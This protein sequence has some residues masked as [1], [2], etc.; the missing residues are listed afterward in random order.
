MLGEVE[1][2]PSENRLQVGGRSVRVEPKTMDVLLALAGAGGETLGREALVAQ[3]WPRGFVSDDALNRCISQLRGALGDTPRSPSFIVTV[4]RV[5]YRLAQAVRPLAGE[6]EAA[7]AL[8]LPFQN[9]SEKA[10]DYIADGLTELLI[11]RLSVALDQPVISRTTAM[12]FRNTGRDLRSIGRQL[13]V[14]WVV[15]GSV[16]QLG[17][18]VQVVVQLID[19][20]SDT[21]VW[22]ETWTRGAGDLL[23]VLNEISRQVSATI[24]RRLAA[25]EARP[26][27]PSAGL[28][29]ALLRKYLH[30]IQL[31][32]RRTHEA[33]RRAGDCFEQVLAEQPGHAPSLGG[34]S[35]VNFL[36]AHYGAVPPGE[37]FSRA[38]AYARQA[39]DEDPGL[40]EAKIHLA[41]VEFFHAWNF[42]E[43]ERLLNEALAGNP[44]LEMAYLLRANVCAVNRRYEKAQAAIDR[45]LQIDPLNVGVLMNAGDHLI[46][47]R[48]YGEAVSMLEAAL[49][50][51][52][53]FRPGRLRLALA[54]ALDGRHEAA[55]DSLERAREPGGEDSSWFEYRAIL[56]GLAGDERGAKAAAGRLQDLAAGAPGPLSWALA[57]A[58]AAA[59]DDGKALD[60]LEQAYRE[61]SSSMPFLGVT[62]VF[63][64]LRGHAGMQALMARVGLSA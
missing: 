51:L 60:F 7:G 28:P 10:T 48:R 31:V 62:P 19:A 57:R 29:E 16:L 18:Q 47:Q 54:Q 37:G 53:G 41:A 55:A 6:P 1:V 61:R 50:L 58:W 40:A 64:R 15:E 23:A 45:A 30:G 4:P 22:A 38:R 32:S 63:D 46:L 35:M 14:R 25:P 2:S 27:Q 56:C 33:L 9:L 42:E 49:E 26:E 11:A 3:V 59:A 20:A 36:L 5:G 44:G 8:V 52:D 39:L 24:S 34:L 12:S 43:A 13:G 21:H 17:A